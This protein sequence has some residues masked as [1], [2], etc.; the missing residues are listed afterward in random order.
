MTQYFNYDVILQKFE[1]VV[2]RTT[3]KLIGPRCDSKAKSRSTKW[4]KD[5]FKAAMKRCIDLELGMRDICQATNY[6]QLCINC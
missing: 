1:E 4:L 3:F 5:N 2:P 6:Y